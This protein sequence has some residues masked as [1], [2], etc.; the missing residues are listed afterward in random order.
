MRER[1]IYATAPV[2]FVSELGVAGGSL[3][4]RSVLAIG[5]MN[6]KEGDCDS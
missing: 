4:Q 2:Y 3:S 1:A 5:G 6:C